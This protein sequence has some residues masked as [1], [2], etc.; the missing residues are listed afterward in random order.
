MN[1]VV[2]VGGGIAGVSAAAWLS[3]HAEVILFE[4]EDVLAFHTTGR[5]AAL[6][7]TNYGSSGMRPLSVA[8]RSYLE[9]PPSDV[10]DG[11]L[12]SNR[13][14]LWVAN[15][16]NRDDLDDL[17]GPGT[18]RLESADAIELVPSLRKHWLGGAVFEEDASDIDVAALHQSFVRR[19]RKNGAEIRVGEGVVQI[20]PNT[21]G[22]DITTDS[23]STHCDV[24]VNAAGAWGDRVAQMAGIPPIG[25]EAKRR[26]AFMVPGR[27]EASGWPMVVESQQEFYFKPDGP[28]FLCSLAEEELSEPTDPRPRMEDVAL[29]IE[30]INTATHLEIKSVNSEWTGLRTFAP[31]RELVIGEEPTAAGFFWLVGQGGTGIQTSPAYGQ[32]LSGLVT[33]GAPPQNLVDAG[34]DIGAY[35]PARFRD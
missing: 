8:S 26:T 35:D 16:E 21:G 23:S 32:L 17:M 34:V 6:Y 31:D 5:S 14:L 25:L 27:E 15:T 13:G 10:V 7:V 30:R 33:S 22:W 1:R 3:E 12:L 24:V 29:A 9:D 2:V 11:P 19:A 18:R 28:Q 4:M 20:E